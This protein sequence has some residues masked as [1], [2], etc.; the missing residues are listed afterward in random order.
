MA[1]T[2][3]SSRQVFE[4][5]QKKGIHEYRKVVHRQRIKLAFV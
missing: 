4:L 1:E 5:K 3:V 2:D